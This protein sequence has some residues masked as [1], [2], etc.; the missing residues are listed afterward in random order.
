MA[1]THL[2]YWTRAVAL[3]VA[4]GIA[5]APAWGTEY[6]DRDEWPDI[7]RGIQITQF[8]PLA[9]VVNELDRTPDAS[10]VVLYPGGESGQAWA[11]EIRDWLVALGVPSRSIALRPGSGE[12]GALGLQVERQGLR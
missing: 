12:P 3:V 7:Q 11:T 4:S 1:V 9:K 10:L 5:G 2:K 8:A 6:I